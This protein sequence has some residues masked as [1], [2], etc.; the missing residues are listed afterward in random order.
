VLT[1]ACFTE[2]GSFALKKADISSVGDLNFS[3]NGATFLMSAP[4]MVAG[5]A[6]VGC[7]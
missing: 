6:K 3:T 4:V 7:G 1:G 2:L 5:M